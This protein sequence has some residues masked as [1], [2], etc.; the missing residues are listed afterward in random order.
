MTKN[1]FRVIADVLYDWAK[2]F[3]FIN[4]QP[5]LYDQL[6]QS[7]VWELKQ[8]NPKF[9]EQKFKETSGIQRE[10]RVIPCANL[11]VS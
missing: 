6:I 3:N 8:T 11:S 4:Q 10:R 9:D 7:L 5:V 1:D 2:G